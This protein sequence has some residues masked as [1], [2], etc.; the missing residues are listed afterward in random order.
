MESDMLLCLFHV[1]FWKG[2][3]ITEK[4]NNIFLTTVT[5]LVES[6]DLQAFFQVISFHSKLIF[7][8]LSL[9]INNNEYKLL[10]LAQICQ[11]QLQNS[12]LTYMSHGCI[13]VI[14]GG[15]VFISLPFHLFILLQF[16]YMGG[17]VFI[18]P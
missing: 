5:L 11:F 12:I 10:F 18:Y 1:N 8:V 9:Y 4:L 13:V 16:K 15:G 14:Q 6:L 7:V 3:E 17:F 2:I